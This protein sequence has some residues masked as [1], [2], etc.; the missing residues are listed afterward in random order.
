MSNTSQIFKRVLKGDVDPLDVFGFQPDESEVKGNRAER[1][2][3]ASQIELEGSQAVKD[4]G[5][6]VGD[7][8]R[9]IKKLDRVSA[10]GGG[11]TGGLTP[12]AVSNSGLLAVLRQSRNRRQIKRVQRSGTI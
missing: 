7:R 12:K 6:L 2:R 11:I 3:R 8:T 1:K 10:F 9:Q 4:A 5:G